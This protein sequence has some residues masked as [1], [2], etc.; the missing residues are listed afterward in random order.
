M[1]SGRAFEDVAL[2]DFRMTKS[3]IMRAGMRNGRREFMGSM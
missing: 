1:K 2:A 3:K